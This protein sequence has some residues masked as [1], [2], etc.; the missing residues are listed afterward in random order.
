MW[1]HDRRWLSDDDQAKARELRLQNAAA[2]FRR[3]VQVIEGNY[4]VTGGVC[5]WWD[6]V[7]AR[8]A[9]P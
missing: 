1:G 6:S 7:K 3:P 9:A 2:G 8:N 5:P 4:Q